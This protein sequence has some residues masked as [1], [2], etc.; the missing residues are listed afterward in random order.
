ML[1]FFRRHRGAFMLSLTVIIIVSFA[2]WGG[3]RTGGPKM[4][5]ASDDAF[6]MYGEDYTVGELQRLERTGQVISM[7]QMYELYFGLMSAARSPDTGGRDFIF[8]L[9]VLKRQMKEL[10]VNPSDADAKVELEKIPG[11]QENGQ[12]SQQRAFNM[13][14]N[15]GMY[16]MGGQDML[17]VAKL[18]IGLNRIKDLIGKNYVASPLEA[19]KAYASRH[20]T[21]KIQTINFALDD[22]KKT[23]EVKDEELQKYYDENKDTYK[24]VEKRAVSYVLFANVADLDKKP[25]EERTKLSKAQ[26]D[27]VNAFSTA[28]AEAGAKFDDVV[29]KLNQKA[30][31]APLFAKDSPPEALKGESELVDAIFVQ[32]KEPGKVSDPVKGTKGWYVFT[33][34]SVEEP[35]QQDLAAVKDKVKEVLVGQKAQEALSKAVNE[36][37]TAIQEGLKGGKK[38]DEIA[39]EKKLTL[40]AVKDLTVNEPAAD[41]P[42]AVEIAREAE[43]AA[44]GDVTKAVNTDKGA[45]LVYVSAKELRKRDDSAAL[46]KNTED[47]RTSQER[48]R[49]FNSWFSAKRAESALKIHLKMSA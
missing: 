28:A 9:L 3:T 26:V 37:R 25:L 20:Q 35:K 8:N 40:D 47:I 31:T 34:T 30:E 13:Q 19:E 42:N 39:K 46:R 5:S 2:S 45:T 10:G 48:D 23:A 11:L 49:L 32:S 6:T 36:A 14:Q 21:L 29:K 12:F 27:S 1:E 15:L 22:F 7:L 44:A 4:A 17:E 16:G 24:S 41:L 18:S 43:K 33:V 38:I